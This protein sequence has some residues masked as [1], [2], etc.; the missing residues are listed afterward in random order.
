LLVKRYYEIPPRRK[1]DTIFLILVHENCLNVTIGYFAFSV[2]IIITS[3]IWFVRN[4]TDGHKP[5][6]ITSTEIS[7]WSPAQDENQII[8]I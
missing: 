5:K 6:R 4:R 2:I 3:T 7:L 1:R 8:F